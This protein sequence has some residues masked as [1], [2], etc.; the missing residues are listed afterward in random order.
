MDGTVKNK[1]DISWPEVGK[2]FQT[3]FTLKPGEGFAFHDQVLPEYAKSVVKTTNAHFNSDDGFKSDGY[4]VGDGVCHLASFIYWVAKD[5]GLASLSL[6]RHD[7]AKIND[8]P[9]EYGVSIRFMPGAFANSSR[10]NLYI[11]NNK[12]VPITF[13][14][15]YN[16]SEL[17]VSVLED[18]GNS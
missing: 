11:V 4:L 5:A 15:D 12:E 7:F 8:V 10:Q 13:T 14:F 17:T 2:P 18:S 1:A 9:R 6:A 3:Q 16:G